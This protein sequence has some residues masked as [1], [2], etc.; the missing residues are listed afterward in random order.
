MEEP[1][2]FIGTI[3][4]MTKSSQSF[5]LHVGKRENTGTTQPMRF[6]FSPN[7][8][9]WIQFRT[10][11]RKQIQTK[12]SFVTANLL[13]HL[14]GLVYR[15]T[16]PN[17]KHWCLCFRPS[18]DPR[19]GKSHLHSI[20]FFSIMNRIRPRRL[21]A[22]IIFRRYLHRCCAPPASC[23]F[24]P[25]LY[26]NDN[27]F[28]DPI[29][30]QTRFLLSA[31]W[32]LSQLRDIPPEPTYAPAADLAGRLSTA[33]SGSDAQLGQKPTDRI[34]AQTD[35]K[36]FI[37]QSQ[38][39]CGSTGQTENCIAAGLCRLQYGRPTESCVLAICA[40]GRLVC[41]ASRASHPPARTLP[42][43]YRCKRG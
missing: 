40:G 3:R 4:Q 39:H 32:L 9:T 14:T 6:D 31:V 43:S 20:R 28:A 22:L 23:P 8:F 29:H 1:A 13:R 34:C 21:T 18:S 27:R 16:I 2:N 5:G 7:S 37:D 25:R 42:T 10:I 11:R 12:L 15:V 19:S 33:V 17:Q 38:W 41:W 26:P 35:P 30:P 36:L 24:V